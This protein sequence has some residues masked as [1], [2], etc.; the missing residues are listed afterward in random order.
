VPWKVAWRIIRP[1]IRAKNRSVWFS[2]ELLVG[3][4][5][6]W[7]LLRF[8][9]FS[10][11]CTRAR[12]CRCENLSIIEMHFLIGQEVCFELVQKPYDLRLRWAVLAGAED[13]IV[14]S[15]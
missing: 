5:W 6:K 11:R 7:N 9:G 12:F 8:F 2:Q 4:K 10:Q 1:V 15:N 3:V 14:Q 13:F